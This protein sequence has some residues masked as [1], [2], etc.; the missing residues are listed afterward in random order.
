MQNPN[1]SIMLLQRIKDL[2]IGLAI[3]DFGTGYSSLSYLKRLPIDKLKIDKSFIDDIPGKSEDEAVV[4]AIISMAKSM[5]LDTV[6]EGVETD[7]QK[8][9]LEQ[10]GCSIIQ[11]YFYSKPMSSEN[12]IKLLKEKSQRG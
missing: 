12:I 7:K 3:D 9:F 11:G 5:G 8:V 10:A 4:S 1:Q 2:G 6:A